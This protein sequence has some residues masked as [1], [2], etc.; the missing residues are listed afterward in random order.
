MS[1]QV[2]G[3]GNFCESV[4]PICVAARGKAKWLSPVVKAAYYCVCGKPAMA[5]RI[6]TPCVSRE[7]QTGKKP[8]E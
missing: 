2:E 8:W 7:K 1:N 6:T 5:L 4:C 3:I